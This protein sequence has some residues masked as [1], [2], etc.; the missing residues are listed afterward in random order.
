MIR[1]IGIFVICFALAVVFYFVGRK[2]QIK[3]FGTIAIY[4]DEE[5]KDY[6]VLELSKDMYEL[7]HMKKVVVKVDNRK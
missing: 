2:S 4:T 7:K 1:F 6:L 3:D 5:G